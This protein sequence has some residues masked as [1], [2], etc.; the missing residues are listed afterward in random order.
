MYSE[1]PTLSEARAKLISLIAARGRP[2]PLRSA[3]QPVHRIPALSTH[4]GLVVPRSGIGWTKTIL[5]REYRKFVGP[6]G[7]QEMPVESGKS[8]PLGMW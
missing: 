2:G 3:A 6:S 7:R 4:D 1:M 8:S 5:S